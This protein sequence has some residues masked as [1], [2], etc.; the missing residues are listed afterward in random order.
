MIAV[1]T[2]LLVY[3]HRAESEWHAQ[4]LHHLLS[5]AQGR[6]QWAIPWPCLH[7]FLAIVTH[8]RI[9]EP[10]SPKE[11][12]LASLAAWLDS[13]RCSPIG[14]GPGYFEVLQRLVSRG[15]VVGG[16]VH[17]A[18][19]AAIC[20]HNGISMLWTADRDFS[21]FPELKTSNPLITAKK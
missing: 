12:A 10:P 18:R 16:L 1:D 3:A 4:A 5:L 20:L 17:D 6:A 9:Y 13:P 21:R 14:E 2:N 15:R 11:T 7:E 8:P 19:V